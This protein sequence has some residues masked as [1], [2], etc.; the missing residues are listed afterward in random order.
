MDVF[1]TTLLIT[2]VF[3]IGSR[4][5]G[6]KNKYIEYTMAFIAILMMIL[7]AGLRANIGDTYVYVDHYKQLA[8]FTTLSQVEKDKGYTLF[9]L[10]LYQV[11][12]DPQFMIFIT[13]LITQ[14]CNLWTMFKYRNLFELQT[15]MYIASGLYLVTMN[16]IRQS[17]TAA[18]LFACTYLII[19]GKFKMY[20]L[21]VLL[22]STIHGSALIMIP[23]YFIVRNEAWTKVTF[24]IIGISTVCFLFFAQFMPIMFKLL[25]NTQYAVYED[26]FASGQEGG[27]S[28]IRFI[29]NSVPVILAYVY[30]EHIKEKWPQSNIFINISILN[31]IVMAFSLYNWI[32]ARFSI[33]FQLYNFILLPYII[34]ECFSNRKERDLIYVMFLICYFIFFYREQVI[35]G[36]GLMYRSKFF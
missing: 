3:S 22:I 7:V 19:E 18:I 2:F 4:L 15:Y 8:N 11:S 14:L 29:V 16:G 31:L 9:T 28:I 35:G 5:F 26:V 20:L 34:K 23:V 32:F 36:L 33:Y 24:K 10:F 13:A 25:E 1:Y 30:R 27:A 21:V 12:T 17:M 6:K